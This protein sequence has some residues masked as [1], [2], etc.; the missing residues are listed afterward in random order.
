MLIPTPRS[1][2]RRRFVAIFLLLAGCHS[3]AQAAPPAKASEAARRPPSEAV[4]EARQLGGAFAE[5]A[6]RIAPAV[7][8]IRVESRRPRA[9][10]PFPFFFGP[11]GGEGGDSGVQRG[12][13][14]GVIVRAD[15]HVLTNNHVVENATRIE[16]ILRDGRR[17]PG[18]VVG[19]DSA[20]DLAVLKIEA[21]EL[22]VAEFADSRESRV[23]EWVLAI[24]SPFG[25]D[26][27][28]TAGVISAVGR[29][30]LGVAEIE[31][32]V[33]TDASINPGNSGG[34]LVNL[35]GRVVGINTMIVGR[36]TGIGFAIPSTIAASVFQQIV[37]TGTVR[38]PW[39][40]V[41]FQELTP[42]LA[43]QFG[44]RT[45]RGALVSQVVGGAP[46]E[47]AG[48]KPGDVVVSVDGREVQESHDLL[49]H[50]LRKNV[51]EKVELGVLREGQP[52]TL[53][54]TT[55]ERPGTRA[56]AER[57]D[58]NGRERT[59]AENMGLRLQ[60]LTPDIAR[61]LGVS[62]NE[63]GVVISGVSDGSAAERIGLRAGDLIIEADRQKVERVE[64]VEQALADG[65]ALLR[66][67]RGE[68]ML[69][70]VLTE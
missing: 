58:G 2:F 16:V 30:G 54:L 68:A 10:S 34:P 18:K 59:R 69:Y 27:T 49:R 47:R 64:Q 13:G 33:Q 36:G 65:K 61:Q 62:S 45:T 50:V 6:E 22:P 15:G 14:S 11:P 56:R 41:S 5:I 23:G 9:Q 17:L 57:R 38:R 40:G 24:G 21:S 70:L 52:R 43:E 3:G 28:V 42:E 7:V 31:D 20:S 60:K 44:L 32:Y 63:T 29:A 66:V 53:S 1:K 25:L 8:S 12:G 46:A 55:E 37:E 39:I 48:I 35:D 4:I 67:R 19:S 51:G 26:Y